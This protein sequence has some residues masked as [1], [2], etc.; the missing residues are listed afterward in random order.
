MRALARYKYLGVSQMSKVGCG[1]IEKMRQ[2]VRILRDRGLVDTIRFGGFGQHSSAEDMHYLTL[3]GARLLVEHDP[4]LSL[5][6]LKYPKQT[7]SLFYNDYWHR[8][9]LLDT[10]IAYDQWINHQEGSTPLFFARYFDKLGNNRTATTEGTGEGEEEA[11]TKKTIKSAT[12]MELTSGVHYSPDGI[13]AYENASGK[14]FL[15]LLEVYRGNDAKRVTASIMHGLQATSEGIPSL[16]YG[17]T[18]ANRILATFEHLGNLEAVRKRLQNDQWARTAE[19]FV[20]FALEATVQGLFSSGWV[21][22]TGKEVS[23]EGF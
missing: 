11:Q 6:E 4:D 23:L 19:K 16:K 13:F 17:Y 2:N 1:F 3:K 9:S 12:Y 18:I 5:S 7:T 10:Q 21:D 20:F 8:H 14:K 22:I 15:Y